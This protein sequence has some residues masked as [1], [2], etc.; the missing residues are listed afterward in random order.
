M[1]HVQLANTPPVGTLSEPGPRWRP[2][3]FRFESLVL[4]EAPSRTKGLSTTLMTSVALHVILISAVVILPLLLYDAMPEPGAAVRAFFAT[5][6][7]VAPPP[8]PPPPPA[9]GPRVVRVAPPPRAPVEPAAFVAPIEVPDEIRPEE[10]TL[11][12]GVEGGVAGGVEGGVAG[13]VL[14][15]VVGGLPA[16]PPPPPKVIRIGGALVA[17]KL[18]HK[19]Q[20]VYPE[21]ATLAH[22]RGIVILEA[23]VGVN[24]QVKE[25]KLL[26][27]VALLD[28]AAM[29]AVKQWRYQPLLLNGVPTEFILTVT[30]NFNLTGEE[31]K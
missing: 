8:P 25:V 18:L 24:G 20:P 16:A 30:V 4:S 1:G 15:G 7:D 26:R 21:M 19:V 10:A 13:G 5:P 11:D 2:S 22:V 27:G 23:Q 12:L 9:A 3:D 28:D 6:P 14:G 17:P 31:A 29:E